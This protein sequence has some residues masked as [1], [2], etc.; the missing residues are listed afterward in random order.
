M[1]LNWRDLKNLDTK[2]YTAPGM[3]EARLRD[4][5]RAKFRKVRPIVRHMFGRRSSLIMEELPFD[6]FNSFDPCI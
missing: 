1:K 2:A 6:D 3:A 5:Q 4:R